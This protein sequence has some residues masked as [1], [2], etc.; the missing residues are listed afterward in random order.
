[1]CNDLSWE[2]IVGKHNVSVE[3][4]FWANTKMDDNG[5]L[6]WTGGSGQGYGTIR[7]GGKT[8]FA[9]RVSWRIFFGEIPK[10]MMI[11]HHCDNPNCVNPYHLFL[12]TAADNLRDAS[13]KGRLMNKRRFT[14]EQLKILEHLILNNQGD[15]LSHIART[16]NF[17]MT[18]VLRARDRV[19][20][21]IAKRFTSI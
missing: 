19:A 9:H 17:P 10:G 15:S 3:E 6:S 12:G 14:R 21:E 5:C 18:T 7:V 4:K 8:D 1:M 11:C 13:E 20:S 2:D 16:Y